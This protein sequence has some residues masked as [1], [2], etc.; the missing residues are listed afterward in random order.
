VWVNN[1][2]FRAGVLFYN[3][4][5]KGTEQENKFN[6]FGFDAEAYDPWTKKV[7]VYF[8]YLTATDKIG[9]EEKKMNGGFIGANVFILPEKLVGFTRYDF[10]KVGSE[11]NKSIFAWFALSSCPECFPNR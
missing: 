6:R 1:A 9:D 4:K 5:M 3:G 10:I 7:N 11:K 8:Q 2:P